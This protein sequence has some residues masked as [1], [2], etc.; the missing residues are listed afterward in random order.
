MYDS[1]GGFY[2]PDGSMLSP[3]AAYCTPERLAAVTQQDRKGF[4]HVCPD[5]VIELLFETDRLSATKRKME[6]WI[7]NGAQLAWLVN[8][9]REEV[10]V[11]KAEDEG[12]TTVSANAVEG[13]GPVDGFRLDLSE[14][15]A[16][17]EA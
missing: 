15:W 4:P 13:T 9:R 6:L 2:L 8:P 17:Y 3:D 12:P 10:L 11:Y 1:S 5:F 16:C 14:V 7:E